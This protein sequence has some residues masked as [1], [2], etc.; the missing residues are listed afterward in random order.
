MK[1]HTLGPN[2]VEAIAAPGKFYLYSYNTCVGFADFSS[3]LE[4]G[5]SQATLA[6]T[7]K[8]WSNTTSRHI[9]QWCDY[10]NFDVALAEKKPQ[11]YFDSLT[12]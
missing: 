11:S 12:N 1:L 3:K 10:H 7:E 5:T 6:I 4:D 9:K 8:K 2:C